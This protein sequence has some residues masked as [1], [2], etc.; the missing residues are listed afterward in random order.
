MNEHHPLTKLLAFK[1]IVGMV[2]LEK[3][4]FLILEGT[5]VLRNNE[6]LTYVDVM[7]GLPEMV[8]CVQM[9]P[10]CLLVLYAYRTK[11][12][13]IPNPPRTMTMRS[14]E[15]QA[16]E[17]GGDQETLMRGFQKR[18]QGGWMGLHAW[19]IYLSPLSLLLDV[20]SAHRMISKA[21]ALQKAQTEEQARKN[22]ETAMYRNG[23]DTAEGA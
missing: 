19:A 12:Y 15:Y 13:E 11:P 6:T 7:M 16:V 8:I 23:Y 1:L 10:L 14:Q 4:I 2:V 21:R 9:V 5:G 3:I 22:E 17:L 20:I 18:Y